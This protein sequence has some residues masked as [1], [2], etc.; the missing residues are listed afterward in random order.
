MGRQYIATDMQQFLLLPL[1]PGVKSCLFTRSLVVFHQICSP[2]GKFSTK[3][4]E[5]WAL[6]C[7]WHEAIAG[8]AFDVVSAYE[9]AI[10][11]YWRR[12]CRHI[13]GVSGVTTAAIKHKHWTLYSTLA[14]V[15]NAPNLRL[16]EIELRYFEQEH[17]FISADSVHAQVEKSIRKFKTLWIFQDLSDAIK[18]SGCPS[19]MRMGHTDFL[20]WKKEVQT[21]PL[22]RHIRAVKLVKGSL[23]MHYKCAETK[24]WSSSH[25]SSSK[26]TE[27]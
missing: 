7:I 15:I 17:T 27:I 14:K 3:C 22:L 24:L 19:V 10:N 20:D 6:A 23:E 9:A 4:R 16:Q 18:A 12:E 13:A 21:R 26:E 25:E 2:I 11:L 5:H 1:I 8:Q